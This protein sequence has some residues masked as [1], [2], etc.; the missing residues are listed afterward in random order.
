MKK[1]LAKYLSKNC[2]SLSNLLGMIGL[3]IEGMSQMVLCQIGWSR[4][5]AREFG[6]P[7]R[8]PRVLGLTVLKVWHFW[9]SYP[10]D[11][12][13]PFDRLEHS[14]L[15]EKNVQFSDDLFVLWVPK[16]VFNFAVVMDRYYAQDSRRKSNGWVYELKDSVIVVHLY[17]NLGEH[18]YLYK[19][20]AWI[21]LEYT[22]EI[23]LEYTK[24]YTNG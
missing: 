5:G 14:Q 11:F 21:S 10:S 4:F 2:E 1:I 23:S 15:V 22:R 16:S 19:F 20:R 12:N 17:C 18:T 3:A 7:W 24:E 6:N 9:K 13:R 8:P